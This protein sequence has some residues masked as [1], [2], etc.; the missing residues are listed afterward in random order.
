MDD[1]KAY[2]EGRVEK[3]KANRAELE[4]QLAQL[5]RRREQITAMLHAHAGAIAEFEG[6]IKEMETEKKE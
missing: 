3:L 1:V 2:A 5:E 6:M 4:Q